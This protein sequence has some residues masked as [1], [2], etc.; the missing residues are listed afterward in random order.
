[1]SEWVELFFCLMVGGYAYGI[2][3]SLNGIHYQLSVVNYR[4]ETNER[5]K[6]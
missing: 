2:S 3:R 5:M 1:M 6:R 4:L